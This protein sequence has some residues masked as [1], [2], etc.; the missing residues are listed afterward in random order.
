MTNR[1]NMKNFD[2]A[3]DATVT[4]GFNFPETSETKNPEQFIY[5]AVNSSHGS[6]AVNRETATA[7]RDHLNELLGEVTPEVCFDGTDYTSLDEHT[8]ALNRFA[9]VMD[10]GDVFDLSQALITFSDAVQA[11]RN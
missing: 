4:V 7:I 10:S 8:V 2:G 3:Y 11:L 9:D 5:V 1:M 6:V